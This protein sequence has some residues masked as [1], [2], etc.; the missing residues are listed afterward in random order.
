MVCVC[1]SIGTIVQWNASSNIGESSGEASGISVGVAAINRDSID[2]YRC[3]GM[4]SIGEE[5]C[6]E[7]SVGKDSCIDASVWKETCIEA[8]VCVEARVCSE[9]RVWRHTPGGGAG[10]GNQKDNGKNTLSEKRKW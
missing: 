8:R 7:A 5:S 3:Y 10:R 6:V 9:A 1:T 2:S 4:V